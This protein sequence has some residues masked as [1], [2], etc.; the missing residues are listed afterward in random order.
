MTDAM[1]A[2]VITG[3]GSAR[4]DEVDIPMPGQVLVDV[5]RA[6]IC[7]TDVERGGVPRHRRPLRPAADAVVEHQEG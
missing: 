5:R 7:G 3:P 6:G 4:V 2:L 1:R